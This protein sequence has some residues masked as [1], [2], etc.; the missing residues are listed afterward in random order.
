MKNIVILGQIQH[1]LQQQHLK[2]LISAVKE[3]VKRDCLIFCNSGGL[4]S[5]A[6]ELENQVDKLFNSGI[7]VLFL[8][9][10]AITRCA[11]RNILEKNNFNIVRPANLSPLAPGAGI[12]R[13]KLDGY[14]F[15]AISLVD[16]SGKILANPAY[17]ELDNF[18]TNKTDDLP[19]YINVNGTD[20]R[21]KEAM[22][23]KISAY[24]FKT[25]VFGSG[26]G[27]LIASEP[28]SNSC[29]FIPD[30]GAVVTQK[31]IG[32]IKP[33]S[34]WRKNIDK[35]P[36]TVFPEWGTLKCDYSVISYDNEKSQKI[37]HKTIK[38]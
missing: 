12:K 36:I 19:V 28:Y 4:F 37:L 27:Y 9:E 31:T 17:I 18:F 22:T 13:F 25:L 2:N 38:I 23:W 29:S 34:W 32:G 21:Y 16:H 1:E 24:N 15:W 30:A 14:E 7:D 33:E 3:D 5:S 6:P 8:G 35:I 20:M 10:Q 26:L 11:G